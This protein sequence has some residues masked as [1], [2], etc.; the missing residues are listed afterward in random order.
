VKFPRLPHRI[1]SFAE[2]AA[3]DFEPYNIDLARLPVAAEM[4]QSFLISLRIAAVTMKKSKAELMDM[5]REMGA[6]R[7]DGGELPELVDHLH[8]AKEFLTWARE[9]IDAAET[10]LFVSATAVAPELWGE[11]A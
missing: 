10:R 5:V 7:A 4:D 2:I 9:V 1:A 8:E 6:E 11:D 3:Q